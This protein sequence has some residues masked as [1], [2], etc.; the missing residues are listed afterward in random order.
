MKVFK[1][2]HSVMKIWEKVPRLL[3]GDKKTTLGSALP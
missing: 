2:L 3:Q 1:F